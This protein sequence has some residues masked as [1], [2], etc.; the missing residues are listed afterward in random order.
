[1]N[2]AIRVDKPQLI[3]LSE[4]FKDYKCVSELHSPLMYRD[5]KVIPDPIN[6]EVKW[7][8]FKQWEKTGRIGTPETSVIFYLGKY[9][10]LTAALIRQAI[11]GKSF[12]S[13]KRIKAICKRLLEIGVFH[14]YTITGD[15]KLNFYCLSESGMKYYRKLN[16]PRNVKIRKMINFQEPRLVKDSDFGNIGSI[17]AKLA[18]NQ[19][20][21]NYKRVLPN[22]KEMVPTKKVFS[23]C[24]SIKLVNNNVITFYC[25]RRDQRNDNL[26]KWIEELSSKSAEF[27]LLVEDNYHAIQVINKIHNKVQLDKILFITDLMLIEQFEDCSY[28]DLERY[29]DNK[30]GILY[31]PY[32]ELGGF[33]FAQ[34]T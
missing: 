31:T 30:H 6:K 26:I 14:R 19:L 8:D 1:M 25:V 27:V 9:G 11:K 5:G 23:R 15:K 20:I 17:L 7:G 16:E 22:Y 13:S 10:I 12:D 2:E 32:K 3:L 24:S 4:E 28:L 29:S 21:I 18:L 33:K 34:R